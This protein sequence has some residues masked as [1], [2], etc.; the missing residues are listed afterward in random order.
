MKDPQFHRDAGFFVFQLPFLKFVADWVFVA[1]VIITSLSVVFHYLGGL[2]PPAGTD[3]SG[4]ATVKVHISVLLGVLALVKAVQY[5]LDRFELDLSTSHVVHGA[6]YTAVHAQ[7]PAKR[8]ADGHLGRGRWALPRQHLAAWV[9]AACDR[10]RAVGAGRHP[11]GRRRT[12]PS[13]RR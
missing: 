11:G 8:F 9:D 5:Y 13:S 4:D 6:T 12:R 2:D 10:G 1:I 7:L 3:Q